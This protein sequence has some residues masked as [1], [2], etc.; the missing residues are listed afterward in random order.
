MERSHY[1]VL[2]YYADKGMSA[3]GPGPDLQLD[4]YGHRS[5]MDFSTNW[6]HPLGTHA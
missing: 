3:P 6:I 4:T 1:K 2:V 5:G